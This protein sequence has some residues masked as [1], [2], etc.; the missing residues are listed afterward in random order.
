[1]KTVWTGTLFLS[2][3]LHTAVSI[4]LHCKF[5]YLTFDPSNWQSCNH[6]FFTNQGVVSRATAIDINIHVLAGRILGISKDGA[7]DG[8]RTSWAFAREQAPEEWRIGSTLSLIDLRAVGSPYVVLIHRLQTLQG[9]IVIK[10]GLA[11]EHSKTYSS[12]QL[13]PSIVWSPR[14]PF[15][16]LVFDFSDVSFERNREVMANLNRYW[17][18]YV[19]FLLW[20][21]WNITH[22]ITA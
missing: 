8:N 3:L 20:T 17:L 9:W 6:A 12:K 14:I 11:N 4:T 1:M 22:I 7:L 13:S 2:S 5:M 15:T 10:V 21:T 16:W 18:V 19:C